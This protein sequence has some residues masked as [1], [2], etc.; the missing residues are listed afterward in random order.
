M[1]HT[2]WNPA[3]F[4]E[5]FKRSHLPIGVE[6]E[7]VSSS[8]EW[9]LPGGVQAEAGSLLCPRWVGYG[10]RKW[11]IPT[12]GG[13]SSQMAWDGPSQQPWSLPRLHCLALWTEA[14]G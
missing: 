4:N 9:G 1:M 13:K 5:Q 11:F 12:V 7:T 2:V 10:L 14:M 8:Q 3:F 6:A